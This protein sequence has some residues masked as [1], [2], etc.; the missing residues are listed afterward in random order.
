MHLFMGIL[1]AIQ[2]KSLSDAES[3]RQAIEEQ[4]PENASVSDVISFCTAQ[5]L[6]HSELVNNVIYC[7]AP[8]P[9]RW[10][11]IKSKWLIQF[12]FEQDRLAAIT[13]ETGHTGP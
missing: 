5:R 4:L 11:L 7:S 13:V 2:W 3:V 8:A 10:W 6:E 1:M 9:N 12:H